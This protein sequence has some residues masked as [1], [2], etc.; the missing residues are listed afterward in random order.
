[1]AEE[2]LNFMDMLAT[3]RV[4]DD[5]DRSRS[6]KE[7]V[8]KAFDEVTQKVSQYVKDGELTIKFKFCCDKKSKNIV[9]VYADITK[10]LP[11]GSQK[12]SFYRDS[13]TGGF[14]LD[15]PEQMKLFDGGKVSPIY[16]DTQTN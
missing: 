16:P 14:Y 10:K 8:E 7:S 5:N 2:K 15:D 11:K 1:M 13:R 3:I 6:F 12:N 9:D 4:I